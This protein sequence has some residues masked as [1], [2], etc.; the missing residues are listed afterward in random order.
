[1]PKKHET[2]DRNPSLCLLIY[3]SILHLSPPPPHPPL[4]CPPVSNSHCRLK[5]KKKKLS[6]PLFFCCLHFKFLF[7]FLSLCELP[8]SSSLFSCAL[9]ACRRFD[10]ISLRLLQGE[11]G[12]FWQSDPKDWWASAHTNVSEP[13]RKEGLKTFLSFFFFVKSQSVHH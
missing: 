9:W 2:E 8:F 13:N 6:I 10:K 3:S 4:L 5:K 1:M 7:S 11:S 12:Q